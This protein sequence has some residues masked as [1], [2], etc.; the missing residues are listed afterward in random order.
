VIGSLLSNA[1]SAVTAVSSS[2]LSGLATPAPLAAGS[3]VG[4]GLNTPFGTGVSSPFG[5]LNP[6]PLGLVSGGT[7]GSGILGGLLST[8]GSNSGTVAAQVGTG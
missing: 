8:L 4:G 5:G 6:D 1:G 3:V 2:L 7:G